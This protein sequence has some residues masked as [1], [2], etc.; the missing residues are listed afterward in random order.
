MISK[1]LLEIIKKLNLNLD[2]KFSEAKLNKKEKILASCVKMS[3]EIW[4]LS[5]EVLKSIWRARKE[6]IQ[7]FS[8]DDLKWEFA[9][10]ILTILLL[11]ELMEIDVNE[12]LEMKLKK[13]E[14][15]WGV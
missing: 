12:A 9:D 2:E 8:K 10:S 7:N 4:E 11:A 13:I 6:K 14:N 15:R 3:E 1:E 5:G